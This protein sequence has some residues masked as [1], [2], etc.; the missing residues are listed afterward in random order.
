MMNLPFI[1]KK[2]NEVH[3]CVPITDMYKIM[4]NIRE[5]KDAQ[6]RACV[7]EI[8]TLMEFMDFSKERAKE[9]IKRIKDYNEALEKNK[10][11]PI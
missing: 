8:D 10:A 5:D 4:Q 1:E 9:L 3:Y 7:S 2:P 6:Y 11:K